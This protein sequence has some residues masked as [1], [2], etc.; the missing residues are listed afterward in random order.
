MKASGKKKKGQFLE[1]SKILKH[2]SQ[3]ARGFSV[4]CEKMILE[5]AEE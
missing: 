5:R 2:K 1:E 3:L 4:M